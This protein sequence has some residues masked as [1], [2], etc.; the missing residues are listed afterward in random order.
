M[1][2][3][4]KNALLSRRTFLRIA[5]IS[6][7]SLVLTDILSIESVGAAG[8][9]SRQTCVDVSWEECHCDGNP[10]IC[11]IWHY[12]K[13]RCVDYYNNSIICSDALIEAYVTGRSC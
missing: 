10:S 4:V 3:D 13:R 6:L 12:K 2:Q 11:R 5:G 8:S 7:G 9:C 1:D